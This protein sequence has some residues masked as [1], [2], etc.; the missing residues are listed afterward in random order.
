MPDGYSEALVR[1]ALHKVAPE[2]FIHFGHKKIVLDNV[3][4]GLNCDIKEALEEAQL[5]VG[6][7]RMEY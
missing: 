4:E 6:V 1:S 3:P 7:M 5:N 2:C